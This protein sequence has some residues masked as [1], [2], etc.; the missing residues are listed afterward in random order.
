[1]PN[2]PCYAPVFSGSSAFV[3]LFKIFY[4]TVLLVFFIIAFGL[5]GKRE[6]V[7]CAF[8]RISFRIRNCRKGNSDPSINLTPDPYANHVRTNKTQF[9]KDDTW[10]Q[11]MLDNR[12]RYEIVFIKASQKPA[13]LDIAFRYDTSPI[14]YSPPWAN[15]TEHMGALEAFAEPAYA[16]SNFNFIFN[17][18]TSASYANLIAG[19]PT[20][21]S[22]AT[23]KDVYLYF[24]TIFNHEFAH[25]MGVMHHYDTNAQTGTGQHMPPGETQCIMDRNI[26]KRLSP[27]HASCLSESPRS[28]WRRRRLYRR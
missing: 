20:N 22:H 19:I 8:R 21:S 5:L 12:N 13:V 15:E 3:C 1:M 4:Y 6:S 26:S 25:V 28:N 23:G 16:G 24:E 14:A 11:W 10:E 18:D 7:L 2:Q 9:G 17:G 27:W